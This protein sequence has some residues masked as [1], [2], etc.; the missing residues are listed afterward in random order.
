M[1]SA[2][3]SPKPGS[4]PPRPRFRPHDKLPERA[5]RAKII[6]SWDTAS[7][8]R[9]Q[10]DWSVCTTWMILDKSYYLIDLTR[11]R[12]EYPRLRQPRSRW[13]KNIGPTTC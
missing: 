5:Y 3:K 12:Y 7:K 4:A 9:A 10:N 13:R 8:D 11:G 2:R 1:N 6:Q